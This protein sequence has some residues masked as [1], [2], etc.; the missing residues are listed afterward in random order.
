MQPTHLAWCW[1]RTWRGSWKSGATVRLASHALSPCPAAGLMQRRLISA[2][3]GASST[4]AH[5]STSS[6][7]LWLVRRLSHDPTVFHPQP[8]EYT[9]FRVG[10]SYPLFQVGA[11]AW[12]QPVP[13]PLVPAVD[14][15][16][17]PAQRQPIQKILG[18]GLPTCSL[19]TD[20]LLDA[21]WALRAQPAMNRR[22]VCV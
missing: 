2:C 11:P 5:D 13:P 22:P 10:V 18:K 4:K 19:W 12:L 20:D 8:A 16:L 14:H 3:G 15:A 17:L 9:R 1:S 7:S 6:P 21:C